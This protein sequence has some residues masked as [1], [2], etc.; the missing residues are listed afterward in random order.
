LKGGDRQ[1]ITVDLTQSSDEF[2]CGNGGRGIHNRHGEELQ[3]RGKL[4]TKDMIG[5]SRNDRRLGVHGGS[6]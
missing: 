3:T 5:P 2:V 6:C 4:L 1:G